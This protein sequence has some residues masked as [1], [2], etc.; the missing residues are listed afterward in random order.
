MSLQ[1]LS[2]LSPARWLRRDPTPPAL[3]AS[4]GPS[5]FAAYARLLHAPHHDGGDRPEGHVPHRQFQALCAVLAQHTSTPEDCYFALWDGYGDIHG[6]DAVQFLMSFSG[7]MR[8][9]GRIFTPEKPPPPEPPAFAP[10]V[11]SG[12][13][14]DVNGAEHFLFGGPIARAGQWGGRYRSGA[15]R[16]INSPNLMWPADHAWV[17]TTHIDHTWS[18]VAGSA[19]LIDH[20]LSEPRLETVRARHD[21]GDLR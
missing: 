14:L 7:P 5:G 19:A 8:W 20:L 9:P 12:P 16:D 3:R 13:R 15:P 4:L 18:G 1:P 21:E 6:G 10:E 2:D 11:M 17:V